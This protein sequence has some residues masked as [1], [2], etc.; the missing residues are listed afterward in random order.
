MVLTG[1]AALAASGSVAGEDEVAIGGYERVM[2][3]NG[4]AQFL[5]RNLAEAYAILYQHYR[6]AYVVPGRVAPRS[7]TSADP[8]D[9]SCRSSPRERAHGHDF[10]RIGRSSTR[11]QRERK[12]PFAMRALMNAVIDADLGHLE[13]WRGWAGAETAI[14]WDACLGGHPS[15]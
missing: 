3:P 8:R 2:G 5:A 4:E 15:P 12:R 6:Y 11:Q 10:D 1:R 7:L 14:V 9:R 13:R